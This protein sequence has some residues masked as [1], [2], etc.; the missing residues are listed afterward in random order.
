MSIDGQFVV[1]PKDINSFILNLPVKKIFGVGKVTNLKMSKLGITTCSHLQNYTQIELIKL[2]GKFGKNLYHLCRGIDERSVQPN[3]IRKSLSIEDTFVNDKVSLSQCLFE[4]N[5][6]YPLL[7]KRLNNSQIKNT[8]PIK[9]LYIKLR[10]NDFK[11]TTAQQHSQSPSIDIY[12]KLVDTAWNRKKLPVR[13]IGLGVEFQQI[14]DFGQLELP[15]K[16]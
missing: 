9:S 11:T 13:L 1:N 3:S 16:Q 12:K 2:F 15:F 7:I 4:I 5:R 14:K 8:L 6:L 10:F